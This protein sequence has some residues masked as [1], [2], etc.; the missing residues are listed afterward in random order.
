MLTTRRYFRCRILP[1]RQLRFADSQPIYPASSAGNGEL[2]GCNNPQTRSDERRLHPPVLRL[3][4]AGI[5]ACPPAMA[6]CSIVRE[7]PDGAPNVEGR[8]LP[9]WQRRNLDILS[10]LSSQNIAVCQ[11]YRVSAY[12]DLF[13]K[14][15]PSVA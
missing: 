15:V 5:L 13:M 11:A 12:Y 4:L 10:M 6:G 9:L 1:A 3:P 8:Y 14:L 7:P 2:R